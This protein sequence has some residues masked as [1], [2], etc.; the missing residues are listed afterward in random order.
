MQIT[1]ITLANGRNPVNISG[2]TKDQANAYNDIIEF[3][4]NDFNINDFTRAL[5]GPAGTGKT[6]LVNALIRNCKLSYSVIGLSAPTHKACRVLAE[7]IKGTTCKIITLQSAL[8][9]RLNFDVEKFDINNPPFD[10][11]GKIKIKDMELFIVDE[12]SMINKGL[13]TFLERVC[14]SNCCK[15]LYIGDGSQLPPVNEKTSS[16]FEHV[17]LFKLNQIVRQDEDNPVRN[18]L[19]I[20]RDDIAHNTFNFITYIMQ[21]RQEWDN[22]FIK[23]WQVCNSNE[24]SELVYNNFNDE[25]LTTN[26]DFC[27]IVAYTNNCV[28][29]WNKFVRNAIIKDADKTIINKNDLILSYTTIVDGFL[30]TVIQN[31]EE[32]IVKDIVNFIHPKYELKGFA[33]KFIAIHGGKETKPLFVVDHSDNFTIQKYIQISN[34]LI[35]AAKAA[36]QRTRA[37]RWKDYY[38]F[39]ESCLLLTNIVKRDGSIL[40]SRD[41]DY[42]F[43]LTGHKAQG[44]TYDTVFVDLN[45]ILYDK[46][47]RPY[48]KSEEIKRLIY[49]SI[50]RCRNKVYL[51]LG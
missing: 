11:K 39:K 40:Y 1:D 30:A 3:I 16:A 10:P 32:Y 7:S 5:V 27:K 42:G 34:D 20:L 25:Q 50:S 26:V 18:I 4:N 43:A 29:G 8:G 37:Q 24:F 35:A 49:T 19:Q 14:K 41:L 33:V 28:S 21:R 22:N 31:S 9:L 45:D 6:Y 48:T 23:G 51:K 13:K 47:G 38:E 2:F 36:G 46:N 12:A 15:I 44:S 17:K